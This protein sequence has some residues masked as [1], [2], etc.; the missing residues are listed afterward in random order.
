MIRS[1]PVVVLVL[2][3]ASAAAAPIDVQFNVAGFGPTDEAHQV[4]VKTVT[5]L[6]S[7][8]F[9]S[10]AGDLAA[11]GHLHWDADDGN[12]FG[13]GFGVRDFANRH[14]GNG[15]PAAGQTYAQDEIEADERLRLTFGTP[16][17][18]RGFDVTDFF[19][20]NEGNLTGLAACGVDD[21][22]CYREIG[23][24]SL[25][26]GLTWVS[27]LSDPAQLRTTPTNGLLTIPV[28]QVAGSV[29]FR[30]PG[31][32]AVPGFP[33]T[34][35]HDFS[36]A[37]VNVDPDGV[38]PAPEPGTF[39]LAGLGLLVLAARRRARTARGVGTLPTRSRPGP[40]GGAGPG[41]AAGGHHH[42]H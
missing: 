23:E 21:P 26:G 24:Y 1:G 17:L 37:G 34:Q 14:T 18:L 15:V 16:V 27:F 25:D 28:N 11:A 42:Q 22:D 32:L 19:Y 7:M 13:D 36:L 3:F 30:A 39:A 10:L 41:P 8:T 2:T 35:M 9:E 40:A 6:P 31:A 4:F 20:E 12:G 5:G 38:V 33:Y 29:L